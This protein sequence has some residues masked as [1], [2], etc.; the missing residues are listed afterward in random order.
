MHVQF[1]HQNV[2]EEFRLVRGY[3]LDYFFGFV[4]AE[5]LCYVEIFQLALL[6]FGLLFD[7]SCLSLGVCMIKVV[8]RSLCK[9]SR[10]GHGDCP[11][12]HRGYSR[13]PDQLNFGYRSSKPAQKY[14]VCEKPV[15]YP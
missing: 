4:L 14:K 10:E 5:T 13:Q 1:M 15:R 3:L 2:F 8:L 11:G 9:E 7:L 12:E 6:L